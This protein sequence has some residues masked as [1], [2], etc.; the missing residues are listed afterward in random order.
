MKISGRMWLAGLV[1][2][3]GLAAVVGGFLIVGPPGEARL[4]RMD[5]RRVS[6]LRDLQSAIVAHRTRTGTLP[7]TLDALV[8][9]NVRQAL[10]VDPVTSRPYA[11]ATTD[12][13]AYELC[14]TFDR[15]SANGRA[16]D[17]D[18]FWAHGAGRQCFPFG[19]Q[20]VHPNPRR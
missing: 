9:A 17:D 13:A 16:R 7:A 3:A 1:L 5:D 10:P 11:Y 19:A 4:R 8:E 14:A 18:P 6:D 20:N 2:T 12:G 15:A